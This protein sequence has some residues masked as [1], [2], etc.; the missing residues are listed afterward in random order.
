[1]YIHFVEKRF[2]FH[3]FFIFYSCL[4][5]ILFCLSFF[6]LLFHV[7]CSSNFS[8]SSVSIPLVKRINFSHFSISLPIYLSFH[9]CHS[10]L[11]SSNLLSKISSQFL[12]HLSVSIHQVK[13]IHFSSS[14]I[15]LYLSFY[16]F[17]SKIFS[18]KVLS[19]I[20]CESFLSI[21]LFI[22]YSKLFS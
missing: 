10:K 17:H 9:L 1:M 15:Y 19:K 6:Q 14:Y 16:L 21:Y 20:Y 11:F 22:Y 8:Y 7:K 18:V 13:R 4:S 2:I 12:C 5:S 3:L